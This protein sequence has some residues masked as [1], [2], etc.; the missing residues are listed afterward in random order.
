MAGREVTLREE[1]EYIAKKLIM[2]AL[3]LHSEVVT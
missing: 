3:A 1:L 2:F